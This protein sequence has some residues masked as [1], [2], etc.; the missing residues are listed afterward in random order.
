MDANALREAVTAV[1]EKISRM[2]DEALSVTWLTSETLPM[3]E[4]LAVTRGWLIDELEKRMGPDKFDAWLFT[5]ADAVD[6]FPF[7]RRRA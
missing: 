3:S 4:E 7:L 5:D 1:Q 6:P 2:S